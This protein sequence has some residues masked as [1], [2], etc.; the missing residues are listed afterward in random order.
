MGPDDQGKCCLVPQASHSDPLSLTLDRVCHSSE[1]WSWWGLSYHQSRKKWRALIQS[2]QFAVS[3][4]WSFQP[5]S[6][7]PICSCQL[8]LSFYCLAWGVW[9][10]VVKNETRLYLTHLASQIK[11]TFQFFPVWLAQLKWFTLVVKNQTFM[12]DLHSLASTLLF[13]FLI[14]WIVFDCICS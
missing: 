5:F 1:P 3:V 6:H 14:F 8:S 7:V 10:L 9:S 4:P 11:W 12:L 13:W 2:P